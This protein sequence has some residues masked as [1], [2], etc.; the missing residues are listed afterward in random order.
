MVSAWPRSASRFALEISFDTSIRDANA[1]TNGFCAG[2]VAV[3]CCIC[4]IVA[5]RMN[6]GG[7]NPLAAIRLASSIA[8]FMREPTR[9]S[10][11]M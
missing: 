2:G 7:I 11:A 10:R 4:E 3:N 1:A 5:R 6:R 9:P 8:S